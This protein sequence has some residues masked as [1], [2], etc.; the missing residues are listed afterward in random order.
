MANEDVG[1]PYTRGSS[2]RARAEARQ[3]TYRAQTLNAGWKGYG[4]LLDDD[5]LEARRNFITMEAW[6][7]ARDRQA[8]GKGVADRTFR[9]MLSSQ[10]MCFNIFAT[11][12]ADVQLASRVLGKLVA[13]MHA[14]RTITFEYTPANEVFRDQ[15]GR[16]G[17]DCDLLIEG[18]WDS[19]PGVLVVETKFVEPEFSTCGFRKKDRQEKGKKMCPEDVQ[20]R[21]DPGACLYESAKKYLYWSRTIEGATLRED[22]LSARGC[23]F[24]GELWQL[25]V[26]HTLAHVEASRM[27]A[28]VARYAVCAPASNNELLQ[29]GEVLSRFRALVKDPS[30]VLF[31]DVDS[32]IDEI[33]SASAG[34]A[35]LAD[36]ARGLQARYHRI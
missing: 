16:G 32:V 5:A 3:R 36:W 2:F 10:A 18:E 28:K 20:L 14:V 30:T 21:G 35:A 31:I 22:A 9:N 23:P 25:W 1:T 29:G 24:G 33:L 11:L 4:H 19:G 26:N 12:Q 7:A 8:A 13:G 17:V 27:G 34:S 6:Q 15:T